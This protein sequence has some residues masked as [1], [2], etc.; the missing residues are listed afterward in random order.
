MVPREPHSNDVVARLLRLLLKSRR[1]PTRREHQLSA[2]AK[3]DFKLPFETKDWPK[4]WKH[5]QWNTLKARIVGN[6]PHI[7]TWIGDTK[8][9]DYT[10]TEKRLPDEGHIALQVHG[11]GDFTKEFVR[12]RNIKVKV[13]D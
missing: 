8:I 12:Y 13:L 3:A 7:T 1:I 10:D 6:P 9:M 11:G 2:E 5:G 4:I